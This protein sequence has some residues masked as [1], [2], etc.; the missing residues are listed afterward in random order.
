MHSFGS[1]KVPLFER[2]SPRWWNLQF[3]SPLL[4]TQYWEC[5]F[6]LLR[7]RFQSGLVYILMTIICWTIYFCIFNQKNRHYWVILY[8]KIKKNFL[9]FFK[10]A[11]GIL[12]LFFILI[13][14][15]TLSVH[16]QR[17]YLPTSFFCSF[18][19]CL[20]TLLIFSDIDPYMGPVA[21]LATSIQV[22]LFVIII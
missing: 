12:L 21:S 20:A 14:L 7:N 2:T 16:Y 22:F 13:F 5:S 18:L 1:Q 8:N 11:S 10:L 19:L 17:F 3:S 6:P 15:F 4:E 9:F